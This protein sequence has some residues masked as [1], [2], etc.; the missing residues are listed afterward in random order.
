LHCLFDSEIPLY[1]Y[2]LT[3]TINYASYFI[4]YRI[5]FVKN[6]CL[7]LVNSNSMRLNIMH[8]VLKYDKESNEAFQLRINNENGLLELSNKINYS[9]LLFFSS[10]QLAKEAEIKV[11]ELL[12]YAHTYLKKL[13][14]EMNEQSKICL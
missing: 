14:F 4:V 3:L 6:D 12:S 10:S 5:A 2:K 9:R 11:K 1:R 7:L 13:I 8:K